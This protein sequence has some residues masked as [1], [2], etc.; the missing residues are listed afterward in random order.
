[1][2]KRDDEKWVT[3]QAYQNPK[4]VEDTVRDLA[5]A[6]EDDPRIRWYRCSSENFESIHSHNAF[7]QIESD[8]SLT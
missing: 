4:F 2:I 7:A 8:K 6:L 1:M 3:E 5:N